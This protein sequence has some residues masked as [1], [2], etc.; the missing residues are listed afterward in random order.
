MKLKEIFITIIIYLSLLFE[1]K[2]KD[3]MHVLWF[4]WDKISR[5]VCW[6]MSEDVCSNRDRLTQD[7]WT[8]S[9]SHSWECLHN[10]HFYHTKNSMRTPHASFKYKLTI[11]R[12]TCCRACGR[13]SC[14]F[15]LVSHMAITPMQSL[16]VL[17]RSKTP[18]LS[19][20]WRVLLKYFLLC[21][22][23]KV[24]G[25]LIVR[26]NTAT[27]CENKTLVISKK[28]HIYKLKADYMHSC[29]PATLITFK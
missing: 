27:T 28:K 18:E 20:V 23:E 12:G 6:V 22:F 4:L 21:L 2:Q 5:H 10:V 14:A 25:K 24:S 17:G 8:L 29:W 26:S 1:R 13:T 15:S 16:P 19:H 9:N 3:Q 7:K 11:I